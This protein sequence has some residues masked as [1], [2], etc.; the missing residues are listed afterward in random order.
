MFLHIM[1]SQNTKKP[2]VKE[3]HFLFHMMWCQNIFAQ[4]NVRHKILNNKNTYIQYV[5]PCGWNRFLSHL[6]SLIII[7]SQMGFF[8]G[9]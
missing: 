6:K 1:V 3:L 5:I 7:I 2:N 8:K 9:M 4:K